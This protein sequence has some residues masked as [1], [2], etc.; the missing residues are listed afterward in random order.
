MSDPSPYEASEANAFDGWYNNQILANDEEG[1]DTAADLPPGWE[2]M[3][4]PRSGRMYYVDHENQI[5]TWDRPTNVDIAGDD[6]GGGDNDVMA[7]DVPPVP[8]GSMQEE[9]VQEETAH[10]TVDGQTSN[11]NN[12]D[13]KVHVGDWQSTNTTARMPQ[14]DESHKQQHQ[15]QPNDEEITEEE[16]QQLKSRAISTSSDKWEKNFEG[17]YVPCSSFCHLHPFTLTDSVHTKTKQNVQISKL[18]SNYTE[19]LAYHKRRVLS[20]DG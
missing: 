18:T 5:T 19:L 13:G 16:D 6:A 1:D 15:Q 2:E 10:E 4:D 8:G 7:Q 11:L 20:V 9:S 14:L 12:N 3:R 17:E